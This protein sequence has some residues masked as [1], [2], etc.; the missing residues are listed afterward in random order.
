M[1][2]KKVASIVLVQLPKKLSYFCGAKEIDPAGG[3]LCAIYDDGSFDTVQMWSPGVEFKFD[4]SKEGPTLVTVTYSGQSQMFQIYIRD[5]VIRRFQIMKAPEKREYLAGERVDLTGLKLQ[6]E[7]ETG[8]KVPYDNIPEIDYAVHNGDAVY[9]LTISGI[10]VPIYIKVQSA[11][12]AGIRMGK[13]PKTTEYLE[14]KGQFDAAGATIIR[15][16]NSGVEEEVPLSYSSVRG[17]SNLVAGPLTL[18]V[19]EGG[20]TTTFEVNIVGK[21]VTKVVIDAPPFKTNYTEGEKINTD[22]IRIS[23]EYNNGERRICED[24][25]YGPKVAKLGENTVRVTV[26]DVVAEFAITVSPRQLV[27]IQVSKL[28]DNIHYHENRGNLDVT[29]AEL[30]L[31]YDYGDP[32]Y[33]PIT[34]RMVRDFDNSRA[35]ECQ[36]E[37]QYE[38]LAA[39]FNVDIIPQQLLGITITQMPNRVD[40]A[41][42]ETFEADGLVVSGF[43]DSGILEPLRSYAISPDRPLMEGDVAILVTALDKTAIIPIKVAEM[44]RKKVEQ[45][46]WTIPGTVTDIAPEVFGKDI[47]QPVPGIDPAVALPGSIAGPAYETPKPEEPVFPIEPP[48]VHD[49][50]FLPDLGFGFQMPP[51]E[52]PKEPEKPK[53]KGGFWGQRLFYPPINKD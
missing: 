49:D 13:L 30:E 27:G 1:P 47:K 39:H 15:V 26:D 40:Y 38:G 42:G 23:A 33:I 28:P 44:F 17:F 9:P 37:V 41:P 35:G 45:P 48:P 22:G 11:S 25:D 52:P 53:K 46:E 36:I 19:Q 18:A 6:A 5:P 2:E 34:P 8:E 10:T 14:K 50:G 12:L 51:P 32:E 7:Y 3:Q 21:K 20:F 4:S 24:W 43:Y 31:Q 29:G 16:Y